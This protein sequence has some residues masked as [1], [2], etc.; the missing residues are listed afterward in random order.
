MCKFKVGDKVTCLDGF[1]FGD[2]NRG[3]GMGYESGKTF[4]IDH[5]IQQSKGNVLFPYSGH[6]I[7]EYAVKHHHIVLVKK[8]IKKLHMV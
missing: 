5:I 8:Y 2:Q 4:I 7:W 1:T 6:G 3:G